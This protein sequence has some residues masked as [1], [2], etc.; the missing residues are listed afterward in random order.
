MDEKE[1]SELLEKRVHFVSELL[2][3]PEVH[4]RAFIVWAE[5]DALPPPITS[6]PHQSGWTAWAIIRLID[7]SMAVIKSYKGGYEQSKTEIT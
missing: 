1:E 5:A 2:V 4:A 6:G 3:I 7:D